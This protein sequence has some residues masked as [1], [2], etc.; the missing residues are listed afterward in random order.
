MPF[1]LPQIPAASPQHSR[2]IPGTPRLAPPNSYPAPPIKPTKPRSNP[3]SQLPDRAGRDP[4]DPNYAMPMYEGDPNTVPVPKQ[5]KPPINNPPLLP[6]VYDPRDR[7]PW[8]GPAPVQNDLSDYPTSPPNPETPRWDF[9]E[10]YEAP[11]APRQPQHPDIDELDKI[12][13]EKI[14]TFSPEIQEYFKQ[15]FPNKWKFGETDPS[16]YITQSGNQTPPIT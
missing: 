16:R 13:R 1:R 7:P 5:W 11:E 10:P 14:D 8:L 6:K 2:R 9:Q 15:L 3:N 12:P 4:Y